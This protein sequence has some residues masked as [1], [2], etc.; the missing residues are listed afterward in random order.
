MA[1]EGAAQTTLNKGDKAGGLTRP[2]VKT[3]YEA[4]VIESGT[5]T[6]QTYRSGDRTESL[7]VNPCLF[8]SRGHNGS[9]WEAQ[10]FPQT[11]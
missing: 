7:E 3:Y 1:V 11:C 8:S 4:T 10:S 2:D 5:V 9:V 6:G